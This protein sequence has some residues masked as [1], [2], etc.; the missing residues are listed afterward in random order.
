M[1]ETWESK[2][3]LRG[4]FEGTQRYEALVVD[5]DASLNGTYK[6]LPNCGTAMGCL[7][8]REVEGSEPIYLFL[9]IDYVGVARMVYEHVYGSRILLAV[10]QGVTIISYLLPITGG[11][12]TER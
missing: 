3:G 7:H 8:K 12:H 4:K 6:L 2:L 5:G 10:D 1:T 9:V 11:W